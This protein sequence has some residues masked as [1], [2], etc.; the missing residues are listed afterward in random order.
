MKTKNV[1]G[2]T[3]IELMITVAIVGILAAV[4]YP[5]YTSYVKRSNRGEAQAYLMALAQK[6]QQLLM[7]SRA[8]T[9]IVTNL[10]VDE[11]SSVSRN[12]TV[13]VSS[14]GTTPPTFTITAA[15]KAGTVQAGD[16]NLSIDQS[17]DKVWAGGSW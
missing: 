13:T 11:P 14:I 4:A 8:Y 16:G 10:E 5:S 12:Y 1:S 2:F 15:P 3:L 9:S 17:G 7:D 6:Q